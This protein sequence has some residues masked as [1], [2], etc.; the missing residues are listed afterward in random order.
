MVKNT[1]L[2]QICGCILVAMQSCTIALHSQSRSATLSAPYSQIEYTNTRPA[3]ATFPVFHNGYL[4]QFVHH[5]ATDTEP[6]V[7][8]YDSYGHVVSTISLW[9]NGAADFY[10]AAI[11]VNKSNQLVISGQLTKANGGK[12]P[13]LEISD[14]NGQNAHYIW[15][16]NYM[17]T[18]VSA[19]DDGSIWT[20]GAER[21]TDIGEGLRAWQNYY[22]LRHFAS[23]GEVLDQLLPRWG[24]DVARVQQKI[25]DPTKGQEDYSSPMQAFDKNGK[26]I[27]TYTAP[28]WGSNPGLARVEHA[29]NQTWLQAYQ[30]GIVLYDGRLRRLYQYDNTSKSLNVSSLFNDS[31]SA[32]GRTLN[33]FAVMSNGRIFASSDKMY[34]TILRGGFTRNQITGIYELVP[35]AGAVSLM[36][37]RVVA[38]TPAAPGDTT[39]RVQLK[40]LGAEGESLVYQAGGNSVDWS[41]IE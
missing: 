25:G 36:Q 39:Q 11:D 31:A 16:G 29:K 12:S 10:L 26:L 5:T 28:N 32:T 7:F 24:D 35:Y 3:H 18:Q 8:L 27:A 19:A 4:M 38:R 15:T 20:V 22:M 14:L 6:D 1:R 34:D 17:A 21:G 33:G 9:P 23:T 37:W 30:N 13:Y 41:Q 40:L 2:L